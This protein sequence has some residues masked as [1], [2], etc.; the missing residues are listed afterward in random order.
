[1]YELTVTDLLPTERRLTEEQILAVAIYRL[2]LHPLANFP[3]PLLGRMTDW[4]S[5]YQAA[6]GNRHLDFLHLHDKYG[7]FF[8][9]S[10]ALYT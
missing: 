7:L 9:P 3:G 6:S 5:V 8:C 1:M 4:Y 2:T 10:L